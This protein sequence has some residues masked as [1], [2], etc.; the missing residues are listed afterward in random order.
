MVV[1]RTLQI[2]AQTTLAEV[3]AELSKCV[4]LQ[5]DLRGHS[6]APAASAPRRAN[7]SFSL[8]QRRHTKHVSI[9]ERCSLWALQEK[10]EMPKSWLGPAV[11]VLTLGQWRRHG[12]REHP[13]GTLAGAAHMLHDGTLHLPEGDQL[14][15][16]GR[17]LR[18]E[19]LTI[20][21]VRYVGCL[22]TIRELCTREVH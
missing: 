3:C 20:K 2:T 16:E 10:V 1:S 11:S 12:R 6:I 5:L 7:S 17:G 19:G 4:D 21:G 14:W 15:L 18:L 22:H 13:S 9:Q 8:V